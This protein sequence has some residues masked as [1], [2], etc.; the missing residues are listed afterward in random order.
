MSPLDQIAPYPKSEE[1]ATAEAMA[2]HYAAFVQMHYHR[3]MNLLHHK[4]QPEKYRLSLNQVTQGYGVLYLLRELEERAGTKQA[5]EVAR[6]LWQEWD[7]GAGI[8]YDLWAWLKEY[9]IDP[10][11][12]NKVAVEATA[13]EVKTPVRYTATGIGATTTKATGQ[14][15]LNVDTAAGRVDIDLG[16]EFAEPMG[17][18]LLDDPEHSDGAFCPDDEPEG[19]ETP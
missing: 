1:E 12:V 8:G 3:A 7:S 18:L 2:K 17:L 19:G 16:T 13:K 15:V 14:V 4:E 5:D 6:L 10:E 11:A 9:G